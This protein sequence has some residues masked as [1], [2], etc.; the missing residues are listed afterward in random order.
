MVFSLPLARCGRF[1]SGADSVTENDVKPAGPGRDPSLEVQTRVWRGCLPRPRSQASRSSAPF[2]C[3]GRLRSHSTSMTC[4]CLGSDVPSSGLANFGESSART[5]ASGVRL[6]TPRRSRSARSRSS[7]V[8]GLGLALTRESCPSRELACFA[9]P[10]SFHGRSRQS[11][12]H[13]YGVSCLNQRPRQPRP[14]VGPASL[15]RLL[16]G[17]PIPAWPGSRLCSPTSGSRRHS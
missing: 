17:F 6:R 4:A 1:S 11:S 3:S 7:S 16:N 9:P 13:W 8:L 15:P 5:L 12:R 14:D 10:Y 2:P